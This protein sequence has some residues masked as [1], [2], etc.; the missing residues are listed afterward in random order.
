MCRF[1][2]NVWISAITY[3]QCMF[4]LGISSIVHVVFAF[5]SNILQIFSFVT[6]YSVLWLFLMQRTGWDWIFKKDSYK[7]IIFNTIT[8][9]QELFDHIPQ[10]TVIGIVSATSLASLEIASRRFRR[11]SKLAKF[12]LSFR[13]IGFDFRALSLASWA[14]KLLLLVEFE[15]DFFPSLKSPVVV[16]RFP[17]SCEEPMDLVK[18][19]I[20]LIRRLVVLLLLCCYW[21][22][23][24]WCWCCSAISLLIDLF[25]TES[26]Q[27][28]RILRAKA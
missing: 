1:L 11:I 24:C 22:W 7:K 25:T 6:M 5:C 18:R 4:V 3:F 19:L 26:P 21:C 2:I 9:F 8:Y 27:G 17:S 14:L 13:R 10:L 20:S 23:C 15:F 28:C 16:K 12:E